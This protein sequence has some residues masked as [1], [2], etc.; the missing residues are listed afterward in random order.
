MSQ[1]LKGQ[2][3]G[4]VAYWPLD[5]IKTE[6]ETQQVLDLSSN[7]NNGTVKGATLV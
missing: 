6:G 1:R 7:G 3:S 5:S 2:E 4:L